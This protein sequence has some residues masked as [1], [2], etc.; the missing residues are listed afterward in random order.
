M[1]RHHF[2]H[3]VMFHS[4]QVYGLTHSVQLSIT[5]QFFWAPEQMLSVKA[6]P[7]PKKTDLT[8]Q[9]LTTLLF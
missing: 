1:H 5:T 4:F 8:H 9:L 7:S 3:H 2:Q 6:E